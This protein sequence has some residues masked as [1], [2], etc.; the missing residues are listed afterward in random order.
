MSSISLIRSLNY[1]SIVDLRQLYCYLRP[2]VK[3]DLNNSE[4]FLSASTFL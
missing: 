1:K 4:L 3:Y 2:N